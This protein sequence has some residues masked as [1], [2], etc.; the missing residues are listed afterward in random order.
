MTRKILLLLTI[1]SAAFV[2]ADNSN[3]TNQPKVDASEDIV[4]SLPEHYQLTEQKHV[5][6]SATTAQENLV[7][8][9]NNLMKEYLNQAELAKQLKD[10]G[11]SVKTNADGSITIH[12]AFSAISGNISAPKPTS[13]NSTSS[14][15][16]S[17]PVVKS[18]SGITG[19]LSAIISYDDV[20]YTIHVGDKIT[21]DNNKQYLIMGINSDAITIENMLTY[22]KYT[23][24]V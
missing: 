23:L 21:L 18:V 6:S 22:K 17:L 11:Y 3:A 10:N 13:I 16:S 14:S 9:Q 8:N 15:L 12:R 2:Y 7:K 4:T 1:S 19:N 24:K 5:L 20:N